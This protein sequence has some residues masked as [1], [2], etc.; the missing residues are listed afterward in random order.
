[1]DIAFFDNKTPNF[2]KLEAYGFAEREGKYVYGTELVGGQ[3][4]LT[5]TIDKGGKVS[6]ETVDV[7]SGEVYSLHLVEGVT[8]EFVGAVRADLERALD[9]IASKCF[10]GGTFKNL[11][12]QAILNFAK[13]NFGDELEFLWDGFPKD[14]V[15][16]RKDSDK[17]YALFVEL[18][19]KKLGLDGDGEVDIA[20][21]RALPDTVA[22]LSDGIHF[23]PAYHMN[24]KNWLTAVLSG[25]A[26][27]QKICRLLA[28]SYDL[29][30]K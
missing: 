4:F 24:K 30:K 16:R 19:R 12:S 2:K 27:T 25:D 10:D 22:T 7:A 21:I 9:D 14:A 5:V 18:K 28:V 23:L 8:G 6:T 13:E 11:A 1:M 26:D 3:L 17:W 29:A 20:V 15:L